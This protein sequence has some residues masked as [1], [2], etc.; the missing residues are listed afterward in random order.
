MR[1][2]TLQLL[3]DGEIGIKDIK[4]L[5]REI[6]HVKARAQA[7]RA[8]I[9]LRSAGNHL[10]QRSFT[11]AVSAH[12]GPSLTATDGEIEAVID[13][14]R[15]VALVQIFNH[16]NLLAGTRRRTELKLNDLA[17]F[18]QLDFFDLIQRLDAAL[19]LRGLG[20]VRAKAINK[21]LLLGQHG[22]LPRKSRLLVGGADV[23][24]TL[25]KII[26]AGV[27]D[28]FAGFNFCDLGD[29]AVHEFAIMRGHEQSALIRLE[30][31]LQPNDGFKIKV[32]RGFVH[33]Q[34]IGTTEKNAGQRDAH[35][36]SA[37]KRAYVAINLVVFKAQAM[38]HFTRLR[39]KRI[40]AQM[41]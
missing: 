40:S 36:P 41:L 12:H 39:L 24:L 22:L 10:E 11:C 33:Q 29:K 30:K 35:L 14:A 21:A 19:H 9:R 4:R 1:K 3:D 6:A 37:G 25:I 18:G 20:G 13:H 27:S 8:G 23:S 5:L 38:E 26:V 28:D 2:I 7:N 16:G 34:N 32:V 17:L 15:A 31:L